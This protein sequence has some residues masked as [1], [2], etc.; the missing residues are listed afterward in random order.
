MDYLKSIPIPGLHQS[1]GPLPFR[2]VAQY[3]FGIPLFSENSTCLCCGRDMDIY[4]DHAL[5]YAS[6]VGQKYRHNLMRDVILDIC[7]HYAVAARK[8]VSL[9]LLSETNVAFKPVDILIHSWENGQD[10]CFDVTGV[11]PFAGEGI[12]SFKIG[13]AISMEV[14]RK[15]NKYLD[16]CASLGYR[17]CTLALGKIGENLF[18]L[19]KRLKNFLTNYDANNKVGGLLFQ[20]VARLSPIHV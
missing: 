1:L 3:R 16:K 5:H 8:E 19:L 17:F 7:Y 6:A 14:S 18:I 11:S 12:R 15:C 10:T 2:G 13:H 4:K 20:I 9:G